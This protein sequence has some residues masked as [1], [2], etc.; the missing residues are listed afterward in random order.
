M[1]NQVNISVLFLKYMFLAGILLAISSIIGEIVYY[2]RF[3]I[4]I[5]ELAGPVE[6]L[7]SQRALY[8]L[9]SADFSSGSAIDNQYHLRRAL[10]AER[11]LIHRLLQ[12]AIF[13][14]GYTAHDLAAG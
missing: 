5:L 13:C 10:L 9:G 11:Y 8:K 6:V 2:G 4:D 1:D 14:A 12:K 7:M 3:K